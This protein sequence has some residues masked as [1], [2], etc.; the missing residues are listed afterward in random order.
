MPQHLGEEFLGQS[1]FANTRFAQEQK[2]LRVALF[3]TRP[4]HFQLLPLGQA[5]D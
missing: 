2:G 4:G 5:V 1:T 3:G